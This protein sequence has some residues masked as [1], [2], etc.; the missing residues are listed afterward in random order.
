MTYLIIS[1]IIV[2]NQ[3]MNLRWC[4]PV[5]GIAF[6]ATK[7]LCQLQN[8]SHPAY[9]LHNLDILHSSLFELKQL[10]CLHQM[11][12]LQSRF[13]HIVTFTPFLQAGYVVL[14]LHGS[15][16][17]TKIASHNEIVETRDAD[18]LQK[19]RVDLLDDGVFDVVALEAIPDLVQHIEHVVHGKGRRSIALQKTVEKSAPAIVGH[20]AGQRLGF[21]YRRNNH[22][23][24]LLFC[25]LDPGVV[26]VVFKTI[27]IVLHDG[28]KPF[29]IIPIE[30]SAGAIDA[31]ADT[32]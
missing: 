19:L 24:E 13:R 25:L 32:L 29:V 6:E 26:N 20:K 18:Q 8:N 5:I 15:L 23:C 21:D 14:D 22:F 1:D 30:I 12:Q 17:R 7:R 11:L 28:H 27:Q 16:P 10:C 31:R 9:V 2:R 4:Q 3:A